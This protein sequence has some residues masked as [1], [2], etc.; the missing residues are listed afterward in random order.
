MKFNLGQL[1][2]TAGVAR[3]SESDPVFARNVKYALN[4]YINCDWGDMCQSDKSLN[5]LAIKDG[6]RILAAYNLPEKK[7]YIITEWDRSVTTILFPDEY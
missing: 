1:V 4:R 2:Q 6:D 5:D 7:I 3:E